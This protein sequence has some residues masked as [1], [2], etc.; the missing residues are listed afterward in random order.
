VVIECAG[1]EE[2]RSVY[3]RLTGEGLSCRLLNL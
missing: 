2:Q 1:E 3:E